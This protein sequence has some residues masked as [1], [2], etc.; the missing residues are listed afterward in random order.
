[1]NQVAYLRTSRQFPEDPH[2]MAVESN[3][4]YVDIANAVNSRT[5]GIYPVNRPAITGNTF[6]ITNQRQQTLRQVYIFTSITTPIPTGFVLSN[7]SQVSQMYGTYTDGI[8]TYGLIPGSSATIGGQIT[9]YI[10][11]DSI[12]FVNGGGSPTVTSGIIVLEWISNI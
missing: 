1:M 5:I 11:H 12:T 7:I 4:S 2:Q 6:F 8:N 3:K 10:D 9:F